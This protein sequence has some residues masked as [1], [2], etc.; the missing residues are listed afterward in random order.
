MFNKNRLIIE[1]H[2]LLDEIQTNTATFASML[3]TMAKFHKYNI[4]QQ[5]NFHFHAPTAAKAL[6]SEE[7]WT[8]AMGT[9]LVHG[10]TPI[11]ILQQDPEHPQN[12]LLGYVY[13]VK[14]TVAYATGDRTFQELPWQ[15]R[16][17][18]D[19]EL[20][21]ET[22]GE[23]DAATLDEAIHTAV[24]KY[25]AKRDTDYPS[26][27]SASVEYIIRT[28]LGLSHSQDD[29]SYVNREGIRMEMFLEEVNHV[30]KDLLN[31]LG[32]SIR[33][34]HT[35]IRD[36]EAREELD[37]AELRDL[38]RDAQDVHEG[39]PAR[40]MDAAPADGQD[41]DVPRN[42]QRN[43]GEESQQTTDG[44]VRT[45]G[46]DR[47]TENGESVSVDEEVSSRET[48]SASDNHGRSAFLTSFSIP[49][50][51]PIDDAIQAVL[52]R[53]NEISAIADEHPEDARTA[54]YSLIDVLSE[55]QG[56]MFPPKTYDDFTSAAY[57]ML[58]DITPAVTSAEEPIIPVVLEATAGNTSESDAEVEDTMELSI[59]TWYQREYPDDA[60][61]RNLA[62]VTFTEFLG[63]LDAGE[64]IYETLHIGA[65]DIRERLFLKATELSGLDYEEIYAQF[66]NSSSFSQT[67]GEVV[68]DLAADVATPEE[69]ETL[70]APHKEW[71]VRLTREVS[72]EDIA[73]SIS[74]GFSREDLAVLADLHENREDL[75]ATIEDL[76]KTCNFH[77][78]R[79]FLVEGDYTGFRAHL[80]EESEMQAEASVVSQEEQSTYRYFMIHRPAG[81]G[82]VPEGFTQIDNETRQGYGF[83]AIMYPR[84]LTKEELSSYEM[85]PA[86]MEAAVI[87]SEE[88]PDT[89]NI[90]EWYLR[91]T[92]D[93]DGH[94]L[95]STIDTWETF[96]VNQT[97]N[98]YDNQTYYTEYAANH[99][100]KIPSKEFVAKELETLRENL[101]DLLREE[102][103]YRGLSINKD[104]VSEESSA[105]ASAEENA[106]TTIS[107]HEM[108]EVLDKASERLATQARQAVDSIDVSTT[109]ERLVDNLE[110]DTEPSAQATAEETIEEGTYKSINEF[111]QKNH[112]FTLGH[113]WNENS[114]ENAYVLVFTNLPQGI[115][116]AT[117]TVYVSTDGKFRGHIDINAPLGE[118][119]NDMFQVDRDKAYNSIDALLDAKIST[120]KDVL[121]DEFTREHLSSASLR[122]FDS[123]DFSAFS[124]QSTDNLTQDAEPVQEEQPVEDTEE[125]A[126]IATEGPA[127]DGSVSEP[128][129]FENHVVSADGPID[130]TFEGIDLSTLD[131]DATLENAA[132]K[133]AVFLRNLAAIQIINHLENTGHRP[134]EEQVR[135][136]RAYSGFGGIPEA[137]D[138]RNRAWAN[139][140]KLAKETLTDAQYRA[141]RSSTLTAFYTPHD[142]IRAI[143]SGLESYGF[144]GGNILDPSTGTGRF[145]ED[146][147]ESMKEESRLYGI[148]LD[149]LTA[150]VAKYTNSDATIFN[151]GFEHINHKNGS[152]DMAITNVPFMNFPINDPE[153]P[154]HNYLIHD[155]F[156]V[157]MLDKV[158]AN[159]L[160]VAITSRGTMDK[161]DSTVRQ[162]LAKKGELVAAFR[163]PNTVFAGA[164]T[165]AVSDLLIFRKRERELANEDPMP[166]WVNSVEQEK[167]MYGAR[168]GV[169][170]ATYNINQYF[171]DNPENILGVDTVKSTAYGY[172][173]DVKEDRPMKLVREED[174]HEAMTRMSFA[175]QLEKRIKEVL[176]E[177]GYTV[178]DEK[179]PAPEFVTTIERNTPYGYYYENNE[180]TFL[181]P[182]GTRTTP[183]VSTQ[184]EER[185]RSAIHIRDAIRDMFDAETH[186]CDDE[187][188]AKHQAKLDALY[189]SHVKNFG[190]INEDRSLKRLFGQ[191]SASTLLMSLEIYD[192]GNYKG[193][194]K[195]FA[196]RTI[197]AYEPPTHADTAEEA[198]AIS[199]QEKGRVDIRYMSEL[200]EKSP[201]EI[202]TALEF[203]S[204]FEDLQTDSFMPADEYLSGN[205]RARIAYLEDLMEQWNE[206]IHLLA[207]DSL[208]PQKRVETFNFKQ[209]EPPFN[210]E[211]FYQFDWRSM[212][213]KMDEKTAGLLM[214]AEYRPV[215]AVC[216]KHVH[217]WQTKRF[218]DTLVSKFPNTAD[219]IQDVD[220][221]LQLLPYAE[222]YQDVINY[223]LPGSEVMKSILERS[224]IAPYM[225]KERDVM[226][227]LAKKYREYAHGEHP[228]AL[229]GDLRSEYDAF[230]KE[231]KENIER[232]IQEGGNR[233]ILDIQS[234]IERFQKNLSAL[235]K[236][237][238]RDLSADEIT[239]NLGASW[240]PPKYI[241]KFIQ[242][243]FR[244]ID[245]PYVE[246]SK[247]TGAW[248]V[249]LTKYDNSK[250]N[251]EYG[252][253]G[254]NALE[255]T[256]YALNHG[257]PVIYK[258]KVIDGEEKRVTDH[259]ATL[260]ATQKIQRIRDEFSKWIFQDENRKNYLVDYYNEKFNC[261][262][263]RKFNGD[264]LSFPGMS[265]E[266]KLRKH[267]KDAVAR[268]L[269]G[270]NTLFAHT[271]GAGKTF[272]M[273]ASAMESK[274]IGL[275]KKPV[276]IMPKH[277]TQQFGSEF[278]RLYPNA[279][280][281]VATEKDSKKENRRLFASKIAS[282][283]WDA[284]VMSYEQFQ[285]IPLSYERRQ[286][287]IQK[288]IDKAMEG[289]NELKRMVNG[290]GFTVKQAEAKI[291]ELRAKLDKMTE[292]YKKHQD[293]TVTFEQL[294]I[295]RL[296]VDESHNYKNLSFFTRMRGVQSNGA[297]KTDDLIA[298]IDYLNEITNERGV[299]FASGTPVSNSLSELYTLQRYLRPSRLKEAD[300]EFFDSWAM[301]FG[302]EVTHMELSPDGKSYSNKTRFARFENVPELISMYHEF[303][304][305]KTAAMLDLDVPECEIVVDKSPASD[306][307]KEMIMDLV[308][309]AALVKA[310][311]PIVVNEAA[312][313]VEGKGLDNMLVITKDG[314]DVALDPRI[315]DK[316]LPDN[317]ESKV[318]HCIKN[319]MDIYEHPS[320]PKSTQIIFCDRS[321]PKPADSKKHE[322]VP[323]TVYE[324]IKQKLI[325]KGVPE[326]EIA[327]IHDYDKATQKEALFQRMRK[328]EVRILL[329]SS[330]KLGVGTNVQD[331]LEATHDLDCP[332]KPSQIEQR[333]GRI[334]RK[335]NQNKKVKI[336]R[337]ITEGSFDAYMWQTNERK[338]R[339]I[340]QIMSDKCQGRSMEDID[341]TALEFS[342]MK[343]ACMDNP[344]Y[345]ELAELQQEVEVLSFERASHLE[346]QSKYQKELVAELPEAI[347]NAEGKIAGYQKDLSV[348]A[349]HASE[350]E[351]NT[352]LVNGKAFAGAE[353]GKAMASYARAFAEGKIEKTPTGTYRGMKVSM[354][355]SQDSHRVEFCLMGQNTIHFPI[356]ST[357]PIE[358]QNRLQFAEENMKG[359]CSYYEHERETLTE[360][361]AEAKEMVEKPF[362]KEDLYQA[363]KIR[364]DELQAI[365]TTLDEKEELNREIRV[366]TSVIKDPTKY[367]GDDLLV[368]AYLE[369]ANLRFMGNDMKWED[370]FDREILREMTIKGYDKEKV[371]EAIF[372]KSPVVPDKEKLSEYLCDNA[373]CR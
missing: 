232:Y 118:S 247:I 256:Q 115:N 204:I 214:S 170:K 124:T 184:E 323:F 358:N 186:R 36:Q 14:D 241:N 18:T 163:F 67:M 249:G 231:Y 1:N 291:K 169:T 20:V 63:A 208:Y 335:G 168:G 219:T 292:D 243:T 112:A 253:E 273:Q 97:L 310:G 103:E 161:K 126:G 213:E 12:Y 315:L 354:I 367:D 28:R 102:F 132:G 340:S 289:Y 305:V 286:A 154:D 83:G 317:P 107:E 109:Q 191:D 302:R 261:L 250:V 44:A 319:V 160:S 267:Q 203:T 139:E 98:L 19:L 33:K 94:L 82:A 356:G 228:E 298:K 363:K 127:K 285:K 200:S 32:A 222:T 246:Y 194:S 5:M 151:D 92:G 322:E 357:T 293:A 299:V 312:A 270:G 89:H 294:G 45:R 68:E 122:A 129:T 40:E 76:M 166:D 24:Q 113:S 30:S 77:Q 212:I 352:L 99:G 369:Q 65:S 26:L 189:E 156:M 71:L 196:E 55:H 225:D 144:K 119:I 121:A 347:K 342:G 321:T 123:I 164:G 180:L 337:Y 158:R 229:E 79:A 49:A 136:L 145:L 150:Q 277:L 295:D 34:L 16:E 365:V 324:D 147:P 210:D 372:K 62:D 9:A 308:D 206:D 269:Y 359:Q 134:T 15:Y 330:E 202:V 174:G 91:R 283:D 227:Y 349:E 23:P 178:P 245:N 80:Q 187:T 297:Q 53:L 353:I 281:L 70:D 328:G 284:I 90:R 13:D 244:V 333:R 17:E 117:L 355:Y 11:P 370:R 54:T 140:Y 100:G 272:E 128:L 260:L 175:E 52:N 108:V 237:K 344:V 255:L 47:G 66:L 110:Q 364:M 60:E 288:E 199:L 313:V 59:R 195:L 360:R 149:L 190:R 207:E 37:D 235:E 101:T 345:K 133:R 338:Q 234:D 73:A 238:P 316:T 314:M 75:K 309:R 290:N 327:I 304:D 282:Q 258:T 301:T 58:A 84:P 72:I 371:K 165:E 131:F 242:D 86:N 135:V 251:D 95:I 46:I 42:I 275:C 279:K 105:Q 311:T 173:L 159:G 226:E 332:W 239:I 197:L 48:A 334:V 116:S 143:Y 209:Y 185:I 348:L 27:L 217:H 64:D 10:A 230:T 188:L 306:I 29:L 198:L 216:L 201:E 303:A 96:S 50:D 43:D 183:S 274:R 152:F 264:N 162:E 211:D 56:T 296:Y 111:L 220:L 287:F 351:K 346:I 221:S 87:V 182:D 331:L 141:A 22:L 373:N 57:K 167:N 176:P 81:P 120:I 307:Q 263:P 179:L 248:K 69:I 172:D 278:N 104:T 39:E 224:G 7:V 2:R 300:I 271:V 106:G 3:D 114:K 137:F 6:A 215:L 35:E 362:E 177:G 31:P 368:K 320:I 268:T 266:I 339:F 85:A 78:E 130:D 93:Y 236:V 343:A 257:A 146:M 142:V 205:I 8:R 88:H 259:K 280:I 61:G 125:T 265:P 366:R 4:W 41:G 326:K 223:H 153:Y 138:S 361:E 218:F 74:Y 171:I 155:Y 25:V 350:E 181:A 341:E 318:N 252:V 240:I 336:F 148:E 21:K 233:D 157:K 325:E 254:K 276:F 192:D 51:M 262:V 38:G 193:K 329:G